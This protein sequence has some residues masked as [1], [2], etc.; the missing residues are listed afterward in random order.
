MQHHLMAQGSLPPATYDPWWSVQQCATC[1]LGDF[2][3][4]VP[5]PSSTCTYAIWNLEDGSARKDV[6]TGHTVYFLYVANALPT[7]NSNSP[8]L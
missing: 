1:T 5:P 6:R 4:P 2:I 8:A 7:N 3:R